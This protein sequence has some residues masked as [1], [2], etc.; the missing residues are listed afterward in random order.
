MENCKK[1]INS[2]YLKI[3]Y[4]KYFCDVIVLPTKACLCF[5]NQQQTQKHFFETEL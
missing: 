3:D 5:R 4:A 2:K 1:N